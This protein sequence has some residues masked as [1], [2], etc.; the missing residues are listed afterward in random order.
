MRWSH[1]MPTHNGDGHQGRVRQD[2]LDLVEPLFAQE[3]VNCRSPAVAG[4]AQAMQDDD[5]GGMPA[6]GRHHDGRCVA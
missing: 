6:G 5:G 3:V 2:E 1:D 4:I